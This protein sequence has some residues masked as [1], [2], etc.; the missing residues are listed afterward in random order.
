MR[1]NRGTA[2]ANGGRADSAVLVSGG[3]DSAVLLA[4]LV[5]DGQT[6]QPLYV[7]SGLRW[8]RVER[9]WLR[10]FVDAIAAPRALPLAEL[11]LPASDLYGTHWSITGAAAPGYDAALDSNY[12][13]GRNL[14]LLSKAAVFCAQHE[15][16]AIALAVLR[17][18][19][20]ADG[21]S[22]FFRR[23]AAAVQS[24]LAV[25]FRIST[26][27]RRLS[28]AQVIRRGEDLPLQMTFSC[29]QPSGRLHCGVC[30]KCAERQRGFVAA[31]TRDPTAYRA[32]VP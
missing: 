7:R 2:S 18:N 13:P 11:A 28:K 31:R 32:P 1:R 14:L 22:M 27:F 16:G 8:E 17:D 21:R 10:R 12:L 6:V 19:P 4:E 26:P 25:P 9:Y 23:F 29:V 5:R 15:I 3:L 20:F 24:G 30:T